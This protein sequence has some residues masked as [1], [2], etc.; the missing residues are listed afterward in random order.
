MKHNFFPQFIKGIIS[1]GSG[2]LINIIF[3][4]FAF[5]II[6]R[7]IPKEQLAAFIL[8]Q[9]IAYFFMVLSDL[10][11]SD[12]AVI[13]LIVSS[14]GKDKIKVVN[15]ALA[16]KLLFGV[17]LSIIILLA[18]PVIL[19]FFQSKQLSQLFW[20]IPL[21]YLLLS[22]T[23]FFQE[24]LKGFYRYREIGVSGK[25]HGLLYF[26]FTAILLII[27]KKGVVGL[28]YAGFL[29]LA[30]MIIYQYLAIPFQKR[31]SFNFVLF[32]K[33][34]RI[35]FLFGLDRF[36]IFIYE[37]IDKLMIGAMLS[38]IG[39]VYYEAASKIPKNSFRMYSSFKSVFLPHILNL[40]AQKK[41]REAAE[42]LNNS[43]RLITL[44]VIFATF[45]ALLFQEDIVV[46]LF[47]QRYSASAPVFPLL[48]FVLS[49]RFVQSIFRMLLIVLGQSNKMLKLSIINAAANTTGN[50][51]MIPVFGFIGAAYAGIFS[52]ILTN[53]F[54]V[55]ILKKSG[56]NLQVSQYIKPIL[57]F[58]ISAFLFLIIKPE[59]VMVKLILVAVFVLLCLLLSIIRK[60]DIF[61]L[62]E[63][64]RSNG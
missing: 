64:I 25:I 10:F 7:F 14:E 23:S 56:V 5:L 13:K 29:S 44:V 12:T 49:F 37:K 62:F 11:V 16:F 18:K 17:F 32:R 15:T 63:S 42:V 2:R 61:Y 21:F 46:I 28:I 38:P 19:Y 34:F 3:G 9:L 33:I 53:L 51:V 31:I 55:R 4:F 48:M 6:V 8:I 20:C 26:L 60:K 47:S 27:F 40:F 57:V 50:L 45:V 39:L 52:Y 30:T 22:F 54:S 35:G 59:T 41:Y 24:I 1:T 36:F 58:V 43:L